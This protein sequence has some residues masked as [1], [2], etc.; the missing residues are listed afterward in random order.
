MATDLKTSNRKSWKIVL[1]FLRNKVHGSFQVF[2]ELISC[3]TPSRHDRFS[4]SNKEHYSLFSCAYIQW[5]WSQLLLKPSGMSQKKRPEIVQSNLE[6]FQSGGV[7][8]WLLFLIF[9]GKIL[10]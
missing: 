4:V 8:G 9:F 1:G 10:W 6:Y 5:T 2:V 7:E 3:L